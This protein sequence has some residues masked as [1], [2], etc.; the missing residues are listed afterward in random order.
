MADV[1]FVDGLRVQE[2]SSRAP[3]W[4]VMKLGMQRE[5]LMDWLSQQDGEWVNAEIKRA[6]SGKLY[7]AVEARRERREP[8]SDDGDEKIPW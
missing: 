3:E 5:K 2:P 7:V 4:I 8:G 1:Q 6:K